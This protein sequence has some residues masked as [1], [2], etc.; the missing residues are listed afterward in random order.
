LIIFLKNAQFKRKQALFKREQGRRR[1]D[2]AIRVGRAPVA[3]LHSAFALL[4]SAC[5]TVFLTACLNNDLTSANKFALTN[6]INT[7]NPGTVISGEDSNAI[8]TLTRVV[9]SNLNT[10]SELDLVGDGSGAMGRLCVAGEQSGSG[11]GA[12]STDGPSTCTCEYSYTRSDGSKETV[13]VDTVYH[14]MNLIRCSSSIIPTNIRF[15]D[16]RVH[17]TNSDAYSNTVRFQVGNDLLNL[18]TA[19]AATFIPVSRYQCH[20]SLYLSYV[21]DDAFYDP[22]QAEDSRLIYPLNFYS[23]NMGG[24]L[25]RFANEFQAANGAGY[26][27]PTNTNDPTQGV[28]L[29]VYS[30]SSD[31]GS[32]R[33]YP[34]T[35]S[36]HD[37]A[38]F[39]LA[40]ER[41]GVFS[42]PV[43]A[44][45]APGISSADDT[46]LGFAAE[47]IP[48]SEPDQET[49]PSDVDIPADY[50]WAKLW[51]FRARLERRMNL[52]PNQLAQAGGL[53]C[54]PGTWQTADVDGNGALDPVVVDC[55]ANGGKP[56]EVGFGTSSLADRVFSS[57][58]ATPR[59]L[60]LQASSSASFPPAAACPNNTGLSGAGCTTDR[61]T[62]NQT[63][64]AYNILRAGS[65]IWHPSAGISSFCTGPTTFDPFNLCDLLGGFATP[66][67]YSDT[68]NFID[69]EE[70]F[71][72]LFVV[73]PVDITTADMDSE[74]AASRPYT[75]FR[76]FKAS[77]CLSGNPDAPLTS[78]DCSINRK[79]DY[80]FVAYSIDTFG[81]APEEN[82]NRL[83]DFP[84]CVLQVRP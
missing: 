22:F 46:P 84:V 31:G 62:G 45:I 2:N 24:S 78:G 54:N 19:D 6:Q 37:R 20:E 14:E 15:F 40:K 52:V 79:I 36:A 30:V 73:S 28:E 56:A 83:P 17:V 55:G 8:L 23:T 18:N 77:D 60:R 35:G 53:A 68:T 74:S 75:P 70:R 61:L 58:T 38:N 32:N 11:G 1:A 71:D 48:G 13:E 67:Q 57:G 39:V 12:A 80:R 5:F 66:Y 3:F 44:W 4:S 27:C 29:T 7:E 63:N 26:V 81:D 50:Q 72:F 59:C 25:S 65:D 51:L 76:F 9:R 21:F 47:P 33:I 82:P 42:V 43:K 49:C 16:V 69:P 41:T 64:T 34:T 10:S